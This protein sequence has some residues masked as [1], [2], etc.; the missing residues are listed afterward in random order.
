MINLE[1]YAIV[2][3]NKIYNWRVNVDK[4]KFIK[5]IVNFYGGKFLYFK[6]ILNYNDSGTL[7]SNL[8]NMGADVSIISDNFDNL[9]KIKN[10]ETL[11]L[12]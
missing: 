10:V 3:I 5:N 1:Q 4:I 11:Y 6:K 9:K 2:K 7:S 12:I 8:L